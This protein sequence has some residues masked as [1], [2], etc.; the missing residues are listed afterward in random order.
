MKKR[1]FRILME[2]K[3]V[4]YREIAEVPE[5]VSDAGSAVGEGPY[6]E[7]ITPKLGEGQLCNT[8]A[9]TLYQ[10]RPTNDQHLSFSK[11][12]TV[13]IKEQQ[14]IQYNKKWYLGKSLM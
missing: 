2:N 12:E 14:V 13:T 4:Y 8:P 5:N 10:Y 11:G 3:N 7:P 6:V 1:L 9:T